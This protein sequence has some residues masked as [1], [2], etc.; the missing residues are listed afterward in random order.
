M[1]FLDRIKGAIFDTFQPTKANPVYAKKTPDAERAAR[2]AKNKA[3]AQAR[4]RNKAVK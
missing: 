4:R 3:A 2:K 1:K